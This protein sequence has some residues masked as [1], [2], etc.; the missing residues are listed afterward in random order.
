MSLSSFVVSRVG[1]IGASPHRFFDIVNDPDVE[2]FNLY[3]FQS[4]NKVFE[5]LKSSVC[6]YL[7]GKS[8]KLDGF[9]LPWPLVYNSV[10]Q[11]ILKTKGGKEIL[12]EEII[13]GLPSAFIKFIKDKILCTDI[14]WI[15]D[16]D[17]DSSF[18]FASILGW[19]GVNYILS[20]KETRFVNYVF[21]YEALKYATAVIVPHAKYIDFFKRKYQLDISRKALFADIDWRSRMVY[22]LINGTQI[23]KLSEEDGRIHV[24]IL[25]GR[26]IWDNNEQRSQGRYY[27]VEIIDELLKEGFVVHLHT[28]A[29]IES[30]DN[31]IYYEPNPYSVL[32]EKYPKSF[33]IEP[34][35]DFNDI[36]SYETLMKYDL[37]LLT[38][39]IKGRYEFSEFEKLNIPNRFYEYLHANV[40]PI[41]P[42]GVLEYMEENFSD[43]VIFFKNVGE[44]KK[45]FYNWRKEN[46]T[47]RNFFEDFVKTLKVAWK[48]YF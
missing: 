37:G 3:Y 34:A 12:A 35:L 11:E 30:L 36:K 48:E 45:K 8:N 6:K 17:F 14:L 31:P 4:E 29:L 9:E 5:A 16:N 21:E 22:E 33:F 46:L 23:K 43:Q 41:C 18:V 10:F 13:Q 42:S 39:G 25:S 27:Y 38:S 44:I 1:I 15:G 7:T 20:L 19:R 40:V 47:P 2:K 24:V 28:K 26:T 32:L